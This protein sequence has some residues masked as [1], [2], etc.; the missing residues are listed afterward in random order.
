MREI[1]WAVLS[2]SSVLLESVENV[3]LTDAYSLY[4][5]AAGGTSVL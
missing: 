2:S 4:A 1:V 3:A 5:A